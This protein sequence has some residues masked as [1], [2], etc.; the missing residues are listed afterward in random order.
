VG[1]GLL[2]E[3][4]LEQLREKLVEVKK[5]KQIEKEA[6]RKDHSEKKDFMV[7]NLQEKAKFISEQRSELKLSN[8]AKRLAKKQFEEEEKRKMAEIREKS[9]MEVYSKIVDK[10]EKKQT[11]EERLAKELREIKLKRQYMNANEVYIKKN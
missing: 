6:R 5:G 3:M 7:Q 8:E 11:E 9:L 4:S 10:K 1:L 2:E